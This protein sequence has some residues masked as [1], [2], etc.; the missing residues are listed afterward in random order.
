MATTGLAWLEVYPNG[1]DHK[2]MASV[3]KKAAV[4]CPLGEAQFMVSPAAVST[5]VI[6]SIDT[7]SV[8]YE[9]H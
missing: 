4:S 6:V 2:T 7:S 9:I 1:P 3:G 5:G 8:S